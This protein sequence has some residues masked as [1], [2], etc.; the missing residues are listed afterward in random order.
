M[1]IEDEIE[2]GLKYVREKLTR[3]LAE[4]TGSCRDTADLA[5]AAL[6]LVAAREGK[7]QGG[8]AP[9]RS[10]DL[11]VAHVEEA[12]AEPRILS[13]ERE[14]AALRGQF[15]RTQGGYGGP[16]LRLYVGD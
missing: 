8:N 13:F 16:C 7:R 4:G 2:Q 15:A 5:L 12:D 3:Q 9:I 10:A 11:R 1:K 6:A 14:L